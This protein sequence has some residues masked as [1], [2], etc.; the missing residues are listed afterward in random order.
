[1]IVKTTAVAMGA[2]L[3]TLACAT[4][5]A[6]GPANACGSVVEYYR[7]LPG[8]VEV[9]GNPLQT[10]TGAVEIHYRGTNGENLPVQGEAA[11]EFS[12]EGDGSLRLQAAT[13]DG[14]TLGPGAV[15]S[16]NRA[17]IHR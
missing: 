9:L 2:A 6:N 16:V 17:G 8:P 10:T 12:T 1:M 15:S 3:L 13:I 7:G 14:K 5:P 4:E 11:C